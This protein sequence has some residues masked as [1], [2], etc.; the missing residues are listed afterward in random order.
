M[1]D[2]ENAER[3]HQ[4]YLTRPQRK[5]LVNICRAR[6]NWNGCD[7]CDIYSG[8]GMEC[9]KQNDRHNC[10]YCEQQKREAI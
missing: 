2:Y 5:T 7:F 4:E 3:L 8:P 10:C 6:P 1:T 9:W